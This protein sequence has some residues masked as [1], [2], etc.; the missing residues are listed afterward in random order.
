MLDALCDE[1]WTV[2]FFGSRS[3]RTL[4][5][6]HPARP[7]LVEEILEGIFFG[8]STL[9]RAR[10]HFLLSKRALEFLDRVA[11][12]LCV[13]RFVD[14][15]SVNTCAYLRKNL[16]VLI[17]LRKFITKEHTR[18]NASEILQR[19]KTVG[20][21]ISKLYSRNSGISKITDAEIV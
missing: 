8:F 1:R 13:Q 4:S 19:R 14:H 2:K 15:L 11:K 10:D 3:E 9:F 21:I 20:F 6:I 7:A 18:Q 5:P 17:I 16:P 12:I